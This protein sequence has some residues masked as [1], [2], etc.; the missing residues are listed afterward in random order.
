[1]HK[2]KKKDVPDKN[3][4]HKTN[5]QSVKVMVSAELSWHGVLR[6]I[7]VKRK[8][9]KVNAKKY[10]KHLKRELFPAIEKI[11][12]R[13]DW[14][15]IQ[16]GATLHTSNIVQDFLQETIP[17]RHLRKDQRP[18]KSPDSNP[19][20]YYFW[21][22]VKHKVYQGRLKKPFETEEKS[23]LRSSLSGKNMRETYPKSEN[24]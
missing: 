13:Q 15:L 18:S 17:R 20:D 1:M 14:I 11:Y 10:K 19:L 24:L 2:G 9:L 23:F 7:F 12:P 4:F 8:G 5:R 3:L 16:D 21:N 22:E 6:P